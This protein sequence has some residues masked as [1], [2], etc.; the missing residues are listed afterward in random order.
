MTTQK[1]YACRASFYASYFLAIH[2]IRTRRDFVTAKNF[3][4][5][6]MH[7]GNWFCLADR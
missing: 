7:E 6:K 5:K 1:N 4:L 3:I 2:I